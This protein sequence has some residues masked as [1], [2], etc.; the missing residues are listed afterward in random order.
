MSKHGQL[1]VEPMQER[2]TLATVFEKFQTINLPAQYP[3]EVTRK[4]YT[5]EIREWMRN[6]QITYFAMRSVSAKS[7]P[8]GSQPKS[9]RG[10]G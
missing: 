4:G 10:R 6:L 2:M 8:S 1:L 9:R 5:Y 3:S 7:L